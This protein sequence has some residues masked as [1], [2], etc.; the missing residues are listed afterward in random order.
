MQATDSDEIISDAPPHVLR[1]DAA[2]KVQD[3]ETYVGRTVT[4]GKPRR[5]L[6]DFWRDIERLPRF[7]DNVRSVETLDDDRC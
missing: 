6:Y 3:D 5:Q 2:K 7:M 1:G 4:I